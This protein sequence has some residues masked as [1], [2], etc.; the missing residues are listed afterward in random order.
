MEA[1][2]LLSKEKIHT[3]PQASPSLIRSPPFTHTHIIYALINLKQHRASA[4][5]MCNYYTSRERK[6]SAGSFALASPKQTQ[7]SGDERA[8][9]ADENTA[10]ESRPGACLLLAA[11]SFLFGD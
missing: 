1:L 10:P 7:C 4:M 5:L 3:A 2:I 9:C 6:V 11:C 8:T